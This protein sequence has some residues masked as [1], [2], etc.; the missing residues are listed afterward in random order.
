MTP[1]TVSESL[2]NYLASMGFG[3]PGESQYIGQVPQ[4]APDKCF[5]LI[6]GGGSPIQ[7]LRTG[8][9]VKQYFVSIY[10]RSTSS[11]DIEDRLHD[12]EELLND[13][14]CVQL[15]E[16]EVLD[17]SASQFPQDADL[18]SI[19]RR[20]GFLQANIQIYKKGS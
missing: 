6:T 10:Y 7:T 20:V 3:V 11:R 15:E 2:A 12:L 18:D 1:I 17:I 19:E 4:S 14:N 5:W 9:K 8:E 16:Y 13:V